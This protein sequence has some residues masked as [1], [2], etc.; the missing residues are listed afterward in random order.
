MRFT[1]ASQNVNEQPSCSYGYFISLLRNR[2]LK[3][4]FSLFLS[5]FSVSPA[6]HQGS[7]E[8]VSSLKKDKSRNLKNSNGDRERVMESGMQPGNAS[9]L[10]FRM[11]T[12]RSV[13]ISPPTPQY[14]SSWSLM[15]LP[16][17]KGLWSNY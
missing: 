13:S 1:K 5:T 3:Y 11:K 4:F 2:Y 14:L 10:V 9:S 12:L 16:S 7:R 15:S 6:K 17:T 8:R